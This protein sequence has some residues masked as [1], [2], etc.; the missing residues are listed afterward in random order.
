[1]PPLPPPSDTTSITEDEDEDE[2]EDDGMPGP[3]PMTLPIGLIAD[4]D[5]ASSKLLLASISN[6]SG[7]L[8]IVRAGNSFVRRAALMFRHVRLMAA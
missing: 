4:S 7:T 6:I 5:R 8:A 3:E 2:D 1:L